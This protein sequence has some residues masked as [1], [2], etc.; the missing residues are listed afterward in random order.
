MGHVG[1]VVGFNRELLEELLSLGYVPVLACLG[2]DPAGRIYNI[3]ADIVATRL[4]VEL[5][6]EDLFLLMDAPGV[7]R[8]R[9]DPATRI[10]RLT[11]AEA[12]ALIQQGVVVG[13]MIPKLEESFQALAGGVARVHLLSG[14]L[15]AAAAEPGSVGTLLTA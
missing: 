3:N 14:E 5:S 15:P 4:A 7:L 2:A 6:A 11:V 8:D 9:E 10:E 1:D 12:R 13:G